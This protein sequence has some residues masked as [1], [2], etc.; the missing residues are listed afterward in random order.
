M[1]LNPQHRSSE[2]E[3]ALLRPS[4]RRGSR[5]SRR[6][7]RGKTNQRPSPLGDSAA[8]GEPIAGP[9]ETSSS[10]HS[11]SVQNNTEH[12]SVES[13]GSIS[14]DESSS[15]NHLVSSPSLAKILHPR[16]IELHRDS[17]SPTSSSTMEADATYT[18]ADSGPSSPSASADVTSVPVPMPAPAVP[19]AE[20]LSEY[21]CPICFFPPTH[22][23]LTPCGHICCGSCLFTAVK[24][25]MQRAALMARDEVNVA[26]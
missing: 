13:S 21:T 19:E 5:G 11:I 18:S 4:K 25:T 8:I 6:N 7:R 22:A 1:P 15:Q 23:T 16:N 10:S 20:P 24:S 26:K 9:S 12:Q 14:P 17:D 3:M 2:D